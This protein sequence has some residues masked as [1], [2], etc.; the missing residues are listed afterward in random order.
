MKPNSRITRNGKTATLK[1]A[2]KIYICARKECHSNIFPGYSYWSIVYN[3]SGINGLKHPDRICVMCLDKEMP[4]E[5]V[6]AEV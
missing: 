6:D 2:R 3:N 4:P 1:E 5:T